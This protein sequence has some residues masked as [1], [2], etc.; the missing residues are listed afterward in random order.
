M[1]IK[2]IIFSVF[3]AVTVTLSFALPRFYFATEGSNLASEAGM[4]FL[5]CQAVAL[6]IA[7][8]LFIH[9]VKHRTEYSKTI[10]LLGISP[11]IIS[12]A[13][14]IIVISGIFISIN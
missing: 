12:V 7:I 3:W 13:F 10:F 6:A 14:I 1:L 9:S 4:A 5:S 2:P 8:Y 11:F